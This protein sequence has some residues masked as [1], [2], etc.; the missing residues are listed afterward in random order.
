MVQTPQVES[1]FLCLGLGLKGFHIYRIYR[2]SSMH[3]SFIS[4]PTLE[5]LWLRVVNVAELHNDSSFRFLFLVYSPSCGQKYGVLN[6]RDLGMRTTHSAAHVPPAEI[7]VRKSGCSFTIWGLRWH[8]QRENSKSFRTNFSCPCMTQLS[9]GS[10]KECL[11]KKGFD[12]RGEGP[13]S[14]A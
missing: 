12:I 10:G 4:W 11:P 6:Q 14:M 3:C 8:R 2:R 7:V 1:R 13:P 5:A 9:A